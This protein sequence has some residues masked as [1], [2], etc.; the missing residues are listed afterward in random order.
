MAQLLIIIGKSMKIFSGNLIAH[1][2]V[3]SN[4]P[5]KSLSFHPTPLDCEDPA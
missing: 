3:E 2:S 4:D 5:G 1:V